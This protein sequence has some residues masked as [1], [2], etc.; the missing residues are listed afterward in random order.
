VIHALTMTGMWRPGLAPLRPRTAVSARVTP[1]RV[2]PHPH[3][4]QPRT[5]QRR[6]V[7]G[8]IIHAMQTRCETRASL[9][10]KHIRFPRQT[11]DYHN[12]N[13]LWSTIIRKQTQTITVRTVPLKKKWVSQATQTRPPYVTRSA[14]CGGTCNMPDA[15]TRPCCVAHW[16]YSDCFCSTTG[17]GEIIPARNRTYIITDPGNPGG[18]PCLHAG[19]Y[20]IMTT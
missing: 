5:A 4:Q 3:V 11:S 18:D 13:R 19:N 1:T 15:E 7:V 12:V 16:Q 14:S 17:D 20:R 10:S 9:F 2:P 6:T 8:G